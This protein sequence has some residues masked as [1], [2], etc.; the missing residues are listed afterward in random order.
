MTGGSH[1]PKR[2]EE[3]PV[4][5]VESTSRKAESLSGQARVRSSGWSRTKGTAQERGA[6]QVSPLSHLPFTPKAEAVLHLLPKVKM[7]ISSLDKEISCL[8]SD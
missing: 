6:G 2:T 8:Q 5:E 7:H 3:D 4:A 1:D